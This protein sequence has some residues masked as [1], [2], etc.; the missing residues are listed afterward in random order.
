MRLFKT[1]RRQHLSHRRL[2]DAV[3]YL[4][5]HFKV[6]DEWESPQNSPVLPKK[7]VSRVVFIYIYIYIY[8]KQKNATAR[9]NCRHGY[10]QCDYS[11]PH[12]TISQNNTPSLSD[13]TQRTQSK[14]SKILNCFCSVQLLCKRR[15]QHTF[16]PHSA[17]DSVQTLYF[18]L[19]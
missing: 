6:A 8:I 1:W 5:C 11:L 12:I 9:L 16:E 15:K 7:Y 18:L 3:H 2:C 4:E 17:S 10:Y 14:T 13:H 19:V